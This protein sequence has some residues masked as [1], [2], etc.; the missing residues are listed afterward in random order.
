M[1][2]GLGAFAN[3]LDQPIEIPY[4]AIPGWP[5]PTAVGHAG[6][7]VIGKIGRS[8]TAVLAGRIHLYEGYS[9]KRVTIGVQLL[10]ALGVR[11]LILTNAAGGI[12]S[13]L[14]QGSLV[15]ISDHINLQ[16]DNPLV[17]PESGFPDMTEVYSPRL[18]DIAASVAREI[19]IDLPQGVYAALARTELRNACGDSLFARDRCGSCRDVDRAGGNHGERARHANTRHLL[20]DQPRCGTSG[21]KLNHTEVI[22]TGNRV[23]GTLVRTVEAVGPTGWRHDRSID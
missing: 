19:G 15:L 13:A 1:G 10:H 20:R 6:K 11:S 5:K 2:S 14:T 12:G 18:R 21:K 17:F 4:E 9:A 16:G 7:L 23:R 22:E 8:P 3:E